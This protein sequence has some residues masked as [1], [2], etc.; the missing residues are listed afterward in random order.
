MIGPPGVRGLAA[1]CRHT[2]AAAPD[3]RRPVCRD[4]SSWWSA[5]RSW[6][7]PGRWARSWPWPVLKCHWSSPTM[8]ERLRSCPSPLEVYSPMAGPSPFGYGD[9]PKGRKR[10]AG[11]S[12]RRPGSAP[13]RAP[14]GPETCPGRSPGRSDGRGCSGG[15]SLS[16]RPV[17][18]STGS[19]PAVRSP[20]GV[21]WHRIWTASRRR[22][23]ASLPLG[24]AG[25]WFTASARSAGRRS[26]RPG[27]RRAQAGR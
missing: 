7:R 22:L 15:R 24:G 14:E 10:C 1:D 9:R 8:A 25:R 16:R 4:A 19:P 18:R 17:A 26:P 6:F 2:G 13:S 12:R 21:L 5:D 23:S 27:R 20:S 11:W 3:P